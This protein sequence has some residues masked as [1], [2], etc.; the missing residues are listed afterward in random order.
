MHVLFDHHTLQVV[1]MYAA[2]TIFPLV[3]G[4]LLLIFPSGPIIMVQ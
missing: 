3:L 4:F 2:F 1:L